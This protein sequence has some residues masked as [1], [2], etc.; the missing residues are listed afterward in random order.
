MKIFVTHKSKLYNY[1]QVVSRRDVIGQYVM[2]AAQ[3]Q[4]KQGNH[5]LIHSFEGTLMKIFVVDKSKVVSG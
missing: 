5:L 4:M 1:R 2:L 3:N